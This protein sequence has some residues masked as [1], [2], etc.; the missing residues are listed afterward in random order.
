MEE[1]PSTAQAEA[2]APAGDAASNAQP[3]DEE[4]TTRLRAMLQGVDMAT[5]TGAD[6]AMQRSLEGLHRP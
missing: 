5:T 1:A 2:E 6:D 4:I 3:S